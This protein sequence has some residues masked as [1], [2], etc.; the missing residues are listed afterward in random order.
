M[1]CNTSSLGS[2]YSW[3]QAFW[4]RVI[5]GGLSTK[6]IS[7][8]VLALLECFIKFSTSFH[9]KS[10]ACYKMTDTLDVHLDETV[11]GRQTVHLKWLVV[12]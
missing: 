6:N 9:W 3:D 11:P 1:G 4:R 2:V 12:F 7:V 8:F 5:R 10:F